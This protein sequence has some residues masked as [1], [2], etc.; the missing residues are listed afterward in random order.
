MTDSEA[1]ID[2][3][4]LAAWEEDV[5]AVMAA[6]VVG[7]FAQSGPASI[8]TLRA[9][10]ASRDVEAAHREAHSLK[11]LARMLGARGLA[12]LSESVETAARTANW[13]LADLLF[14]PMGPACSAAV[15]ALTAR[16][17]AG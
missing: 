12:R 4:E 8:E 10:L 15:D 1:H 2:F 14:E 13:Q 3:G 7:M 11:S 9:A 5:G 17:K 6:R 16:Y